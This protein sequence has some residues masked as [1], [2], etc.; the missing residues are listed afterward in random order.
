MILLTIY[1]HTN[2]IIIYYFIFGLLKLLK[3]KIN[4]IIKTNLN[5]H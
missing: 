2:I 3:N 5:L 4:E 1:I